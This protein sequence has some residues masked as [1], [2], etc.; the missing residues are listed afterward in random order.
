M[1][2]L[3]FGVFLAC[4]A[5]LCGPA[6]LGAP[7]LSEVLQAQNLLGE[8]C[9]AFEFEGSY[10][11]TYAAPD[12]PLLPDTRWED[13]TDTLLPGIPPFVEGHSGQGV[14]VEEGTTNLLT[15][16]TSGEAESLA[17]FLAVRGAALTLD[18]AEPLVGERCLKVATPG[19]TGGEGFY[20]PLAGT[21]GQALAGSLSLRGSG[22]LC[23]RMLD[24]TNYLPGA[25]LYVALTP[26]WRRYALPPVKLETAD[27]ADLRLL[28]TTPGAEAATFWA[29]ALQV[30]AREYTT[31]WAPGGATR[32]DRQLVYPL[33][34][35]AWKLK[36]GTVLLW[37]RP[38]WD[39]WM[40][41]AR[42]REFFRTAHGEPSL[43]WTGYNTL[44]SIPVTGYQHLG[45][46]GN[47][48][49]GGWQFM[50]VSWNAE[51]VRLCHNEKSVVSKKGAA[52]AKATAFRL[53]PSGNAVLDQWVLLKRALTVEEM[54]AVYQAS[55]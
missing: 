13:P 43:Y 50:A 30:E 38:Q 39:Q 48:F 54:Q 22:T 11:P 55:K 6:A 12:F 26:E 20:I 1:T 21:A 24:L 49:A 2:R 19:K 37:V 23:L 33:A 27:S 17:D 5:M 40:T 46:G 15:P 51:E 9:A 44:G 41:L 32:E 47:L 52:L 18:A 7:P 3:L 16:S 53:G 35:E 31:S 4:A 34:G 28:V 42:S 45:G 14:L 8:V 10:E 29:D 36:E 25:P